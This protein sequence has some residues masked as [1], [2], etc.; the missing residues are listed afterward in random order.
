[1]AFNVN[2]FRGELDFG[3]AR[4][5][6]FEVRIND[7]PTGVL[8]GNNLTN[9]SRYM[10]R[11]SQLPGS[12]INPIIV[13]YFGRQIKVAGNRVFDDWTTTVMND[14][15]FAIRAALEDWHRK[16]NDNETNTRDGA[17][18]G[19]ESYK[20]TE[21]LVIQYG[22]QGNAI[23]TY[24]FVGFYPSVIAPIDLDWGTDAIEEF[25]VTW[26][27]DYWELADDNAG[28]S[29]TITATLPL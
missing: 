25:T 17:F 14:E 10:V 7:I 4:P 12:T 9:K 16:I 29:L 21:A 2:D 22:K 15:D 8:G 23:R 28:S 18:A 26:A 1:M 6:L 13:P 11:A 20:A 19:P 5:S 24:R 3:G 27:Y